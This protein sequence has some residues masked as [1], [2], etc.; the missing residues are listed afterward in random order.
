MGI[1][2]L[3]TYPKLASGVEFHVFDENTFLVQ[4]IQYKN[5]LRVG[6]LIHFILNLADGKKN[7][8]EITTITQKALAIEINPQEIYDAIYQDKMQ[9]LGFIESDL[10]IIEKSSSDYLKLKVTILKEEWLHQFSWI[11]TPLFSPV[12]FYSLY[13]SLVIFLGLCFYINREFIS[14]L[15][16]I[17]P[18][19]LLIIYSFLLFNTF[20]HEMGHISACRRFGAKH[21]SIGFGFY[22]FT[23]V[24]FADV[25]DAWK[26]HSSERIILDLAGVYMEILSG[27]I[28]M[29]LYFITKNHFL[30]NLEVFIL[31][32]TLVNFNPFM[33]FDGYWAITDFLN[34]PNLRKVADEKMKETAK[35]AIGKTSYPIQTKIDVFLVIYSVIS[36]SFI[37]FFLSSIMI[38]STSMI[39]LYPYHLLI[40]LQH[41]ILS[42][43]NVSF[44]WIKL[45]IAELMLPTV[46]YYMLWNLLSK[47]LT[48]WKALFKI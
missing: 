45:N 27:T 13:I 44:E 22:L 30:L 12:L 37:V 20:L 48:N 15:A 4:Q 16:T 11:F 24:F 28:V 21:G 33:R 26:L 38:G 14:I 36:W 35:W 17:T 25:S 1:N 29:V 10:E 19:N 40:F 41:I 31:S 39:V 23:P 3:S 46:F 18:N 2:F 8:Q 7:I 9:T 42:L 43:P 6:K 32:H 5:Q 34:I 47:R